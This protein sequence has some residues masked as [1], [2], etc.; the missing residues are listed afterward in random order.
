MLTGL[1][2]HINRP[3]LPYTHV[4]LDT[5]AYLIGVLERLGRALLLSLECRRRR[6]MQRNL[7]ITQRQQLFMLKFCALQRVLC[8]IVDVAVSIYVRLASVSATSEAWYV[9]YRKA[10]LHRGR[11]DGTRYPSMCVCVRERERE[12]VL[13]SACLHAHHCK[14]VKGLGFR[15]CVQGF[16][17]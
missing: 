13:G 7:L 12:R 6:V 10:L 8:A 5:A 14:A 4:S 16:R 15:E 2:C 3:L 11:E 9:Y 1:F 17:V